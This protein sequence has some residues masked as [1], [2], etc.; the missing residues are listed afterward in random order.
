MP[1]KSPRPALL[2][3]TSRADALED[4]LRD[5]SG[6][7]R[8]RAFLAMLRHVKGIKAGRSFTLAAWQWDDIVRPLYD[9]FRADGTRQ[10]RHGYLSFARKAG[11]TTLAAG[12]GLYHTFADGEFGGE[13]YVAASSREQAALAFD[14]AVGMTESC[15]VLRS[16]ATISRATKRI[17]DRVTQSVFRALSADVPHLHGLNA[18]F[19]VLDEV[20]QQPNRELYDVLATSMGARRQPLMLSIGTAGW[21]RHSI[22]FELYKHAQQ[23]LAGA[24]EDPAFFARIME[25]P[26]GA[27]WTD[28]K[29]WPLANPGLGDFRDREELRQA[30]ERAKAVPSQQ[31]TFRNLY[32]NQWVSSETRWLDLAVWDDAPQPIAEQKGA[33]CYAALD[34]SSSQ[35]VT[36]LAEI[37]PHD[38][39]TFT[40]KLHAW[41][42][43]E[44]LRE[45]CQRDR[46]PYDEWAKQGLITLV[47]GPVIEYALIED[48][49]RELR[50]ACDLREVAFDPWNARQI[51]QRLMGEGFAMVEFRQ[52]MA[53]FTPAT[54]AFEKAVIG[55]KLRHGGNPLLRW[56]V[57]CCTVY[58]DGNGNIRPIK[59]DRRKDSRRIDGV[60]ASI[61]ALDRAQAAMP[62]PDMDAFLRNPIFV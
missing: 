35:D 30:C 13:V 40:L 53:N 52:T 54:K 60:V 37:R 27:D 33:R 32:C 44:N 8:V 19:V 11:K 28:E 15:P 29:L 49:L 48:K 45:R 25:L 12:L 36:A 57:D 24:V 16:R 62:A 59:P 14:V 26:E 10:Y 5:A 38:D 9:T 55:R 17:R 34:L 6:A 58:A 3:A 31:N 18:S 61:M 23:V 42:P 46:V 51:A 41:L 22:A 21:D 4:F 39:G 43:E 56:M 1:R 50:A 7:E 47:P 20:A 2:R